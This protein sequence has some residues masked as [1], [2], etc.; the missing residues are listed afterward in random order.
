MADWWDESFSNKTFYSYALVAGSPADDFSIFY[1]SQTEKYFQSLDGPTTL[2]LTVTASQTVASSAN[3]WTSSLTG[4]WT[5]SGTIYKYDAYSYTGPGSSVKLLGS[6]AFSDSGSFSAAYSG[7][8]TITSA[9]GGIES[10]SAGYVWIQDDGGTPYI[11]ISEGDYFVGPNSSHLFMS[12]YGAAP[13][14]AAGGGSDS[15]DDDSDLIQNG[16]DGNDT[17]TGGTGKDSLYGGAG[18]DTLDGGEGADYMEGGSGADTYYV[19]NAKDVVYEADNTPAGSSALVLQ[20]DLG[21]TIDSVI[22]SVKYTLTNYVE[23]LTLTGST[24]KLSGTGNTLDNVITGSETANKISGK[25]GADTIDGGAG[26]DKIS[27][28][29][30]ADTFIFSNLATGGAD[31][32]SDF[33]DE[34]V[35][36]FDTSIFTGLSGATDA[37]LVLGADAL[38]GN[39][40]LLY[41]NGKLYY[42]ADGSGSGAATLIV[43]LKGTDIK[44]IGFEDLDFV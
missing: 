34:D 33:A 17:L 8:A 13:G 23:N 2:V 31:A 32:I 14:S 3:N 1:D 15:S 37:N 36:A 18:D 35:L 40:Y 12:Y 6:S 43:G 39:D 44:T 9:A 16:T 7:S 41:N 24:A 38:D 4:T 10:Q 30:G 26:A 42:D 25:E 28:G 19:D 27:G 20:I 29:A 5:L 22:S 11:E 21:S